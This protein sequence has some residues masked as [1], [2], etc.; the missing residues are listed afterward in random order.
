MIIIW[1]KVRNVWQILWNS[2]PELFVPP[3]R[4]ASNTLVLP[5]T[6][7]TISSHSL[8][9]LHFITFFNN[10]S[11]AFKNSITCCFTSDGVFDFCVVFNGCSNTH[12]CLDIQ[13]ST[14]HRKCTRHLLAC[15]YRSILTFW[16]RLVCSRSV[17]TV[18]CYSSTYKADTSVLFLNGP[19][20]KWTDYDSKMIYYHSHTRASLRTH[21]HALLAFSVATSCV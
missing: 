15:Y 14:D 18:C 10:L 13:R 11:S 7:D 19:E 16:T 2:P 8:C 6:A 1:C 5:W 12:V 3:L 9:S 17:D 20:C 21:A 4:S